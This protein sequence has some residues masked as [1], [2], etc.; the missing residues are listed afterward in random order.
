MA[1]FSF[2]SKGSVKRLVDLVYPVGSLYMSTNS[3]NP[4]TLF[5]GTWQ[6]YAQGRCLIGA[7]EGDDGTTSMS[8]APDSTGGKY[9][10]DLT[11]YHHSPVG[12]DNNHFYMGRLRDNSF[13]YDDPSS[14]NGYSFSGGTSAMSSTKHFGTSDALNEISLITPYTTVYIW[15]RTA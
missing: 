1:L 2:K 11:H 15:R 13:D 4:S 12:Y 6:P 3:T 9:K 8:F 5:G 14:A 10:V 7:G